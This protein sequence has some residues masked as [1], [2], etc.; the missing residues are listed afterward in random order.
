MKSKDSLVFSKTAIT[1]SVLVYGLA[2]EINRAIVDELIEQEQAKVFWLCTYLTGTDL[3]HL[4]EKAEGRLSI[5][6]V[7]VNNELLDVLAS[8]KLERFSGVVFG[9]TKG[10]VRPVK[11]T[12]DEFNHDL[13]EVNFMSFMR[14]AQILLKK[15]M[16]NDGASIVALSSVSSIHGLKSKS[17]YSASKAAL[18]AAVKGLAAEVAKQQIRANVILKGWVSSDMQQSFIQDSLQ[19][20]KDDFDKQLL[21]SIDPKEIAYAVTFLLSAASKSITGTS[22][23]IDGGYSL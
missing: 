12:S 22:I 16:L 4:A 7:G 19:L 3:G 2:N 9:E 5:L 10:G 15:R 13:I 1:G 18:N 17:V 14:L 20:N 6:Q 21:G 11:F 8:I 23:I